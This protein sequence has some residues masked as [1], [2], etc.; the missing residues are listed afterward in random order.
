CSAIPENL[1]ESILFGSVKGAY[2]GALD[3]SGLFEEAENGTLFLDE[4]NSMPV[5]MQTKLLRALQEKKVR[6]V[7]GNQ[8]YSINCRIISAM[9]E[10][11]YT[12]I[13]KDKLRE[14]LFYRISGYNIYLPKL[15]DRGKDIF[16]L[17]EHFIS[18]YNLRMSK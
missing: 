15:V 13:K 8:D 12:L 16:D 3:S 11:P 1:L 10:D 6:R 17:S 14:D 5:N 4:L 7:G 2:T 18:K 9:G